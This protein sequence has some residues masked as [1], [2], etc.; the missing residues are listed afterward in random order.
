MV[1][2][3]VAVAGDASWRLQPGKAMVEIVPS[4]RDKGTAIQEYMAESP[5]RGRMPVFVGDDRSDEQGFTAVEDLGGLAIKVGPGRTLARYRLRDVG[6][7]CRWLGAALAPAAAQ[8]AA[9]GRRAM[10]HVDL[11]ISVSCGAPA[12]AGSSG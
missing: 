7:V 1:R 8:H 9:R 3:H 12:S 6:A 4:G 5:F 11:A 2:A 10:M